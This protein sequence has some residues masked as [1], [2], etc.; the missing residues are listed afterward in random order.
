LHHPQQRV[1]RN[2]FEAPFRGRVKV[3]F[4]PWEVLTARMK[5]VNAT[6]EQIHSKSQPR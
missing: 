4:T 3:D 2:G 6:V 5:Q 1:W